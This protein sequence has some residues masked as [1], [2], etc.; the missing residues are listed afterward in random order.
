MSLPL[1]IYLLIDILVFFFPICSCFNVS[2][3]ILISCP[4]TI[5]LE[6]ELLGHLVILVQFCK[7]P[8][9][10]FLLIYIPTNNRPSSKSCFL[11]LLTLNQIPPSASAMCKNLAC[12]DYCRDWM[13]CMVSWQSSSFPLAHAPLAHLPSLITPPTHLTPCLTASLKSSILN[14][15]CSQ[16]WVFNLPHSSNLPLNADNAE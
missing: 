8:L 7:G 11:S 1:H 16:L 13:R 6:M 9:D 3:N 10:I 4:Y 14:F 12:L 15:L 2:V 5:Y